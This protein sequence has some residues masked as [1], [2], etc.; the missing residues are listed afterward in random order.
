MEIP[1]RRCKAP[2]DAKPYK[3]AKSDFTC[4]ACSRARQ[5]AWLAARQVDRPKSAP[6]ASLS[7][8][9]RATIAA[10]D[11]RYF[12][13][14]YGA[15]P[16]FT[17]KAR[18]RAATR[19]AIRKGKLTRKPCEVCGCTEVDAHHDDYGQPYSVRWLCRPH[20]IQHHR[21]A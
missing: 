14:R 12:A 9:R 4:P 2:F 10:Q 17:Q 11:A 13:A 5:R 7:P 19:Y 18:T 21:S 1:C 8:A 20:H 16:A 15:D 6:R 3:L